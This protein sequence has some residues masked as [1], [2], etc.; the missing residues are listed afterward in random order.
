MALKVWLAP[1]K[2]AVPFL[3]LLDNSPFTQKLKMQPM[4]QCIFRAALNGIMIAIWPKNQGVSSLD[5]IFTTFLANVKAAIYDN[6]EIKCTDMLSTRM[7]AA[8]RDN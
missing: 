8:N 4:M 2:S 3:V 7:L 6:K 1:R 5:L